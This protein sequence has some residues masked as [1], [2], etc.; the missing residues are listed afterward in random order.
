MA[1][2]CKARGSPSDLWVRVHDCDDEPEEQAAL[3]PH[4]VLLQREGGCTL[5]SAAQT[6][7]PPP[8]QRG[9]GQQA[10]PDAHL[11]EASEQ[12]QRLLPDKWVRVLQ[13][14]ADGRDVLVHQGRVADAEVTQND[15]DVVEDA[16]IYA[17]LQLPHQ[18]GDALLCEI[19]VL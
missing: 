17:H 13:T 15:D 7:L 19:L 8:P 16:P 2:W 3:P 12:E 14:R 6:C 4:K 1:A 5:N 18:D 10:S 11:Q 9:R